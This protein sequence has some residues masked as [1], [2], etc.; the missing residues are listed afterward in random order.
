MQTVMDMDDMMLDELSDTWEDMREN[1]QESRNEG[2][3]RSVLDCAAELTAD[4]DGESAYVWTLGLTL[5]A[6]YLT[7]LPGAGVAEQA[8]TALEAADRALRGHGCAHDAHPYESHDVDQD[9]QL[10]ELLLLI[11]DDTAA[12]E[13]DRPRSEWRCPLNAAGFARIALDIVRPGSVTDVPPRLPVDAK[14][15]IDT[16]A[17][18]L[19]GYPKPWTD[20]DDEISGQAVELSCAAPADRAGRLMVVRAVTWYAVSGTVHTK[21]V[22]DSLIRSVEQVVPHFAEG[23]CAHDGHPPLPNSGPNAAELGITLSS[24]GGRGIYEQRRIAWGAAPLDKVVCPVL[25]G[26]I[27]DETLAQL[28]ER[29]EILFGERDT[30]HADAEYLR[31]DGRLDIEKLVERSDNKHWNEKYADDLGLWAARRHEQSDDRDRAVLLLVAYQAV[32]NAYPAPPLSVARG[33]LATMRAVAAAPL[34]AECLHED[35]HPPLRRAEFRD[36]MAHF[37]APEEFPPAEES[38][39]AESWMCPRFAAEVAEA[40]IGDLKGLYEEDEVAGA[41]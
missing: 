4:P 9:E 29:Y 1:Y 11:A 30:S 2:Y 39:S 24:P 33:V 13:E 41:S 8:V 17:A 12:W 18:L 36:G 40:C 22:L 26:E 20:I 19:H 31:A 6:P 35:E 38:R 10:A 16:L 7:W 27:A 14:A 5:M 3:D 23:D 28:R 15:S 37:W 34:P 25:M 21:S 32:Q